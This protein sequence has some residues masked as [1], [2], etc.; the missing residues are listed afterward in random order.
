MY[1]T[2]F[3]KIIQL[4]FGLKNLL[5][6]LFK[7]KSNIA[8]IS[9]FLSSV[10]FANPPNR[11]LADRADSHLIIIFLPYSKR[12]QLHIHAHIHTPRWAFKLLGSLLTRSTSIFLI[13]CMFVS[14]SVQAIYNTNVF[15]TPLVLFIYRRIP[16]GALPPETQLEYKYFFCPYM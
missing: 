6:E 1:A 4:A 14:V 2:F 7:K 16:R 3:D 11:R 15:G 9:F 10:Q 12:I 5:R 8:K 13:Q